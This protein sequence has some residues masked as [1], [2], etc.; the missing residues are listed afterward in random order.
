MTHDPLC[1]DHGLPAHISTR[2]CACD[3]DDALGAIDALKEQS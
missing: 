2:D 1:M 3:K